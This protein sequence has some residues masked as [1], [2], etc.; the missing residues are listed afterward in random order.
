MDLKGSR[1]EEALIKAFSREVQVR[2]RYRLYAE[3]AR[4]QGLWQVA[5]ILEATA[6]NEAEHATQEFYFL[7]GAPDTLENLE[8]AAAREFEEAQVLY[9]EAASIAKEEGFSE[10]AEFLSRTAKVEERHGRNMQSILDALK[11]SENIKGK[12]VSHSAVKMSQTMMPDQTNPIGFVHGGELMKLMDNAAAI[13]ALRHSQHPVVTAEVDSITFKNSV[14]VGDLVTVDAR[15]TFTSHSTME[16][17]ICATAE[18]T[19][20]GE[21]RDVLTAYFIFVALDANGKAIEVPP[22]II[23][24]E[25][26]ERLFAEG[27]ARYDK[28][29]QSNKK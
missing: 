18:N 1:T 26:E 27:Q 25:E 7:G 10:I 13:V 29:K 9:P 17:R 2:V 14:H 15:L 19:L 21:K 16:V 22:L 4:K 6:N 23:S 12:T 24:T 20:T 8:R 28:R 5:D 3:T 11:K